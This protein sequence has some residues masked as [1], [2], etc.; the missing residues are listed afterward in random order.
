M[1]HR[2]IALLHNILK[3][4][5]NISFHVQTHLVW[6]SKYWLWLNN[7]IL[8]LSEKKREQFLNIMKY[9]EG[10]QISI[11]LTNGYIF[12]KL[13]CSNRSTHQELLI[14]TLSP[15]FN[16]HGYYMNLIELDLGWV[17]W[18]K[19]TGPSNPSYAQLRTGPWTILHHTQV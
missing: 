16:R 13:V 6:I 3:Q 1:W 2:I 9:L 18:L 12:Q 8:S 11:C 17:F 7:I 15:F 4:I 14:C 10:V 5:L 19:S